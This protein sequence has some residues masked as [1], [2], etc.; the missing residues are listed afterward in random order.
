MHRLQL[1][2]IAVWSGGLAVNPDHANAWEHLPEIRA[3][4]QEG[5]FAQAQG[6]CKKWMLTTT[7]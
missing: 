3:D 1:N 5:K 2:D 7:P 6:L 4:L